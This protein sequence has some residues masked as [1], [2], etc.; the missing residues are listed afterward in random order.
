MA[1]ESNA[2]LSWRAAHASRT[3]KNHTSHGSLKIAC[4]LGCMLAALLCPRLSFA[5]NQY[6]SASSEEMTGVPWEGETGTIESVGEIMNRET[7]LRYIS[8]TLSH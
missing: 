5:A 6:G 2:I 4:V 1:E 7:V 8:G 3:P